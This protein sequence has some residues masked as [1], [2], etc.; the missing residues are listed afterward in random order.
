[1]NN[2]PV[3]VFKYL[4]LNVLRDQ[5]YITGNTCTKYQK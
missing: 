2:T 4:L 5:K 1:M 3:K